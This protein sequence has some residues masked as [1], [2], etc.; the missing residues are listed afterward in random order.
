MSPAKLRWGLIFIQ[1][2]I[3]IL[4]RNAGYLNDNF[5]GELIILSPIVLIAIGIEKIFTK[6]RLQA[7][8][9]LSSVALFFGGFFIAFYSSTGGANESFFSET[10][11]TQEND[12]DIEKLHAVLNFDQTNLTIR[13]SGKDLIYGRFDQFTRKP[14]I[15]FD[16]DNGLAMV[17]LT[18]RT[19]SYLGCTVS[20]D[21]DDSQDWYMRFNKDVPLDL[22]CY[23]NNSDIHLNLSSTPLNHLTLKSDDTKIYLK[24]G[25][26]QS[27]VNV[28]IEGEDSRLRLRVPVSIGI[29]ISGE[30]YKSYLERIGMIQTDTGFINETYEGSENKIDI[31]LDDRLGS[32]SLDFF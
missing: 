31:D 25:D 15:D 5:W 23:S 32:F 10:H 30:A 2:G 8:A 11:F 22:E 18:G 16:A 13:D 7:I 12:P 17:S 6:T 27:M 1:I 9:Y 24:L 21:Q 3:L 4:L 14:K 26:L 28:S 20:I 19:H 29:R